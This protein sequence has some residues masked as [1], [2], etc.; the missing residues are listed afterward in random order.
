MRKTLTL[1]AATATSIL[2]V[3]VAQAKPLGI[4]ENVATTTA[5]EVDGMAEAAWDAAP[6]LS[7]VLDQ[8]PYKPN[9]GYEGITKTTMTVRSMHDDK[10]VY[11]FLEWD[12]PTESL[13]RYPWMKQSDGSWKQLANK[14]DTGHDNTYYED[15]M[16]I[17]WNID[18]KAF[19]KKGCG[20]ACHMAKGGKQKGRD[21]KAPGRKYTK[22]G[23][24][25][26]MWHWKGVRTN[27]NAQIDD[28]FIDDN[29]DP[30]KN[31]GWGRHGD[32]KTGGGYKD[33]IADGK[34]AFVQADL[35]ADATV[36]FESQKMP[37]SSDMDE[38]KRIPGIVTSA[39]SGSRGDIAAK[40]VWKDGKWYLEIS[41]ALVTSGEKADVQDVQFN[42]LKKTYS[43]GLSIFDNSQINH[44]YHN[45]VLNMVF[46]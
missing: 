3:P 16:S 37:F 7:V 31:K 36:I 38:I 41:R 44:V 14:D 4:L 2:L 17:L 29:T 26:D 22:P 18:V 12:D 33:N 42:D 32:H 23:T 9:N 11:F 25:L 45:G 43:F 10:N 5:I 20:A 35:A 8:T 28:Q 19:D 21:D 1:I 39:F 30:E 24:T 46:K 34:P 13:N 27:P 15:K 6:V 40:G